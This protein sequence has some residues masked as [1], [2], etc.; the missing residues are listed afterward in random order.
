MPL[1]VT[2]GLSEADLDHYREAMLRKRER[3]LARH[4]GS[5]N[6]ITHFRSSTHDSRTAVVAQL[7]PSFAQHVKESRRKVAVNTLTR[8][9]RD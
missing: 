5:F 6:L 2:L 9:S 3:D 7:E 4:G 1:T 8:S